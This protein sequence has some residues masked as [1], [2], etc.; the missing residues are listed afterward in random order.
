VQRLRLLLCASD[1]CRAQHPELQ[2]QA[3]AVNGELVGSC[4]SAAAGPAAAAQLEACY[5]LVLER[6]QHLC[7]ALLRALLQPEQCRLV[8]PAWLAAVATHKA[9]AASLPPAAEFAPQQL[10]LP[11]LPGQE[12]GRVLEV[13]AWQRPA[14]TLLAR[15]HLVFQAGS[16]VGVALTKRQGQARAAAAC[17]PACGPNISMLL[18]CSRVTLQHSCHSCRLTSLQPPP[19]AARS[20]CSCRVVRSQHGCRSS[21][22]QQQRRTGRPCL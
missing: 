10:L 12:Q 9:C 13:A 21:S 18:C 3:D 20:V 15:Y 8:T 17:G 6:G 14:G 2:V 1:A 19:A 7:P 16:E 4:S 5:A 11:P 22:Q